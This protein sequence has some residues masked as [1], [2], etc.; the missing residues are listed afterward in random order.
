MTAARRPWAA[1]LLHYWFHELEPRQW[2]ASDEVVDREL[3]RR[4]EGHLAALRVRPATE[5]LSDRE[6]AR[7]AILLFDQVPRNLFRDDA[8]AF[9]TDPLAREICKAALRKRWDNG[10]SHAGKQFVYMPLM[11]S[12]D[13]A[14]Q[15]LSLRLF[16][17]LGDSFNF[18]F[19][20]SHHA[21]IARFGRF[22][23]RNELLGR[24]T[25][26]AEARAIAAGN[27]W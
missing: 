6:T 26:E 19:A 24:R 3:R 11:H 20:R 23:H 15:R 8:R 12:E 22:P 27:A 2:F 21:M 5:F 16:A 7:A 25:T 10:L 9:A 4:F 18:R 13:I 17:S 1:D 14:D